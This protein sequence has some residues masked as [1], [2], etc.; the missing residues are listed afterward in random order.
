MTQRQR[1][2][3]SSSEVSGLT[4]FLVLILVGV[5]L[6]TGALPEGSNSLLV[7]LSGVAGFGLLWVAWR[8]YEEGAERAGVRSPLEYLQ[9]NLITAASFFVLFAGIGFI[10]S[11]LLESAGS[12]G[13]WPIQVTVLLGLAFSLIYQGRALRIGRHTPPRAFITFAYLFF[14][15]VFAGFIVSGLFLSGPLGSAAPAIGTVV[16]AVAAVVVWFVLFARRSSA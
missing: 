6:G 3:R 11:S 2:N 4:I 8:Y 7:S 9:R 16:G 5:G 10:P 14:S 12:D 1:D 13:S 15:M